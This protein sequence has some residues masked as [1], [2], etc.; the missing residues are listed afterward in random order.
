[1]TPCS[2]FNQ[3][4]SRSTLMALT[5]ILSLGAGDQAA[6]ASDRFSE[7]S[8]DVVLAGT[9]GGPRITN[10]S[11]EQNSFAVFPGYIT[12]NGPVTGWEAVGNAGL[13]PISTGQSPFADNGAIPEGDQIGFLQSAPSGE[14]RLATLMTGLVPGKS[15][16][17]RFRANAR[18]SNVVRMQVWVSGEAIETSLNGNPPALFNDIHPVG[19]SNPYHRVSLPFTA[20]APSQGLT[21]VNA[22]GG[23]NTVLLDDF[24]LLVDQISA[25]RFYADFLTLSFDNLAEGVL[26]PSVVNNDG[27]FLIQVL[28]GDAW[29]A[30]A[31]GNPGLALVTGIASP[32]AIGDSL[33]IRL[34]S[35]ER[36]VFDSLEYRSAN[37]V[38]SDSVDLVWMVDGQAVLVEAGLGSASA[39]WQTVQSVFDAPIDELLLITSSIGQDA[40]LLDNVVVRRPSD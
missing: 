2:R 1:M 40:L 3:F 16:L 29:A 33:S 14:S 36:F 24:E 10:P 32:P 18:S 7:R 8:F 20:V 30:L 17:V 39:S 31:L 23:D 9:V 25:D 12:Q 37:T 35:G 19:G 11:F 21:I 4:C 27:P 5:L 28:S 15:Y 34:A 38:P 6:A 26:E 22:Q 13:N